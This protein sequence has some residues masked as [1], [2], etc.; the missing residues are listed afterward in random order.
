MPLA[1]WFLNG[2]AQTC[3]SRTHSAPGAPAI[4]ACSCWRLTSACSRRSSSCARSVKIMSVS[5]PEELSDLWLLARTRERQHVVTA[6]VLGQSHWPQVLEVI[7][8]C[9]EATEASTRLSAEFGLDQIQV[10][11]VLD[12]QFRRLV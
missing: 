12:A 4:P 6:L 11:A 7:A 1:G 9:D 3:R 8:S 10:T 5:E 2:R